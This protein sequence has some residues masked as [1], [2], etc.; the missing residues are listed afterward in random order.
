M[1]WGGRQ[2]LPD[3]PERFDR[4]CI[5]LGSK[6]FNS[7]VHRW[8]VEVGDSAH[9][10]LGVAPES[11][12]RKGHLG[13][14]SGLWAMG[15][16][17]GIYKAFSPNN[18]VFILPV[19]KQLQRITVLLDSN[20]GALSFSELGTNIHTFSVPHRTKMFPYIATSDE[21]PLKILFSEVIIAVDDDDDDDDCNDSDESDYFQYNRV[22]GDIDDESCGFF[23]CDDD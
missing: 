23:Y 14:Q 18:P 6:G 9:W 13:S 10:V 7:G 8:E 17:K 22:Y 3:N 19:K 21:L 5:V 11:V 12:Q 4:S 2:R 20:S 16:Y 15:L 1:R